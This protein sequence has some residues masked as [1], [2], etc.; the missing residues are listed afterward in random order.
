MTND[1]ARL[2]RLRPPVLNVLALAPNWL[3]DVVMCT[4][5]LRA[6]H[7]RFPDA[8]LTVAGRPSACAALDR[9]PW[10]DRFETMPERPGP[11]D[12]VRTA[13]RLRHAAWDLT[14]VFPHSFRA[15]LLA[16]LTGSASRIG[17]SRNGRAVLLS[18]AMAPHMENGRIAP[19][20]MGTEYLDLVR[21]LGCEDDGQGL[22]LHA[23]P[24]LVK[25]LG[26]ELQGDGPLVGLAAGAAFGPSKRWPAEY[27]ARVADLLAKE[28]GARS[29]ILTG[30]G[31]EETRRAVLSAAKTPI[32]QPD[33]GRPT[34]ATLKAVV[35]QLDLLI[36]NDSGPR[37]VAVAFHVPT[38]C[39][40]GPTSPRYSESPH[41][42]G[43]VLRI[44]VD[45]GPCQKP[46]CKTDH[47]CMRGIPPER[48]VNAALDLL[49]ARPQVKT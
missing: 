20:Y 44:D 31:E 29:V 22:E 2:Q 11:V 39:I 47:R 7:R 23:D 9:L 46:V 4:P 35:S 48:V 14:V 34:I 6:L 30:P 5:A 25:A 27:Y 40:M 3:G 8:A 38:V 16:F 21:A 32:L 42:R 24:M 28:A 19:V 15:A 36:C 12:L 45:C 33:S 41:E 43:H 10:I 49:A 26:A 37:H 17:Y 13:R 18:A 1:P